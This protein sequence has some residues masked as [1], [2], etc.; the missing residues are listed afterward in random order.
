MYEIACKFNERFI[1]V[2]CNS[3]ML[4]SIEAAKKCLDKREMLNNVFELN[5]VTPN[6]ICKVIAN[7]KNKNSVG[8]DDIP[9]QALK[10]AAEAISEPLSFILNQCFLIS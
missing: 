5:D 1:N 8:W 7:L 4:T 10:I 2:G 3:N 6:N 9:V